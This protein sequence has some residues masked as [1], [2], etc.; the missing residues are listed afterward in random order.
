MITY[1]YIEHLVLVAQ[2]HKVDVIDLI[3]KA[4]DLAAFIVEVSERYPP[5]HKRFNYSGKHEMQNYNVYKYIVDG[6]TINLWMINEMSV[7]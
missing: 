3:I 5:F 1:A 2:M 4:D 7:A 6:T